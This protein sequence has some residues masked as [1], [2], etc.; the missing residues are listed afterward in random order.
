ML[1]VKSESESEGIV[2]V[3]VQRLPDALTCDQTVPAHSNQINWSICLLFR[4]A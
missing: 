2:R 3:K 4:R 1:R